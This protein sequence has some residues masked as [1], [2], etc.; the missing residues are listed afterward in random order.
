MPVSTPVRAVFRSPG[1]AAPLGVLCLRESAFTKYEAF[2]EFIVALHF[3]NRG[4]CDEK[5]F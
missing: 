3:N 2:S 1:K 4:T 5:T